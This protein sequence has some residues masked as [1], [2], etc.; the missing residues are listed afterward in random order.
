M[1]FRSLTFDLSGDVI[2]KRI[3]LL[4]LPMASTAV[5]FGNPADLP[6]DPLASWDDVPEIINSIT[7]KEYRDQLEQLHRL[8][9]IKLGYP[10]PSQGLSE[11]EHRL[12]MIQTRDRWKEWWATTGDDISKARKRE[13]R[14]DKEA[15]NAAWEFL[16]VKLEKPE[17]ILPVWIPETW[18]LCVTF[19]NSDYAGREKEVWVIDRMASGVNLTKLRG[20]YSRGQWGVVFSKFK[21]ITPQQAD[22][23]LKALHYLHHHA[24]AIGAKLP[25]KELGKLY[26]P[27]ATLHLRDGKD[28]ILWNAEGYEFIKTRPEYGN[29]EAGRSYYYLRTVFSDKE[30]WE[31][32]SKPTTEELAPYRKLLS[33]SKPYFFAN[34]SDIILLFGEYGSLPEKEVM[35]D[36]AEKQKAATNPKM[37]WKMRCGDFST[38]LKVNVINFTKPELEKTL[39]EIK[40]I[41]KRMAFESEIRGHP[42][43]KPSR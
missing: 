22:Q 18:T 43:A 26:Y 39:A 4:I 42:S 2:M 17:T 25:G 23:T 35:L 10:Q 16:D 28:R 15:F 12:Y 29:G 3:K 21:G 33:V 13:A 8:T 9:L 24:P 38:T 14:I 36:W 27:R 37:D 40:K 5:A 7:D 30:R 6:N 41:E 11:S 20:D 1:D 31:T 32:P 19:T 34:A